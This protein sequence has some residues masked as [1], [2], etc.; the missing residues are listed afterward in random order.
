MRAKDRMRDAWKRGGFKKLI[1]A[2]K[3]RINATKSPDKLKGIVIALGQV[4]KDDEFPL[5][6]AQEKQLHDLVT[7]AIDKHK[8]S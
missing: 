1:T 6:P 5:T 7:P 4:I 2:T 8:Y 3:V